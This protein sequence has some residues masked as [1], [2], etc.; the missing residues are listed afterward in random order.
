VPT[1]EFILALREK[2]GHDP[3][4]LPGVTAVV[5][6]PAEGGLD[7]VLIIRRAD[8]G[9]W[10]PIAGIVEPGEHPAD[11]A[12]RE[13]AEEAGVVAEVERIA[14]VDVSAPVTH[15]NGDH[16]RYLVVVL[17]L[18]W[19]SGNPHPVD[20]EA[21]EALWVRSDRLGELDPPLSEASLR[22]IGWALSGSE[23]AAFRR[24]G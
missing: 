14:G 21:T 19:I 16:S 13:V 4:W 8:N 7:E 11:C 15:Q 2:I 10:A 24:G 20:G 1:P 12:E 22:R 23:A 6:R 17:R 5:V 18:R 3:L 9:R